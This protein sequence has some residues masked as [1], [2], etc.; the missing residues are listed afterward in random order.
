MSSLISSFI[1]EPVVRQARRFS[2]APTQAHIPVQSHVKK[3]KLRSG[4]EVTIIEGIGAA[5]CEIISQDAC[6]AVIGPGIGEGV[7]ESRILDAGFV[8]TTRTSPTTLVPG[9]ISVPISIQHADVISDNAVEDSITSEL[10]EN[11]TGQDFGA[12]TSTTDDT[13]ILD[14]E[15]EEFPSNPA[16]DPPDIMDNEHSSTP[17]SPRLSRNSTLRRTRPTLASRENTASSL[18][19]DDGMRLMRQRIHA[20]R[21]LAETPED[22]ARRM[23]DLMTAE[24]QAAQFQ[25]R[26]ESP[27]SITS[28]DRE[29][30]RPFL[31]SSPLSTS[32]TPNSPRSI[33]SLPNNPANPY[34]ITPEDLQ[35]SYR[36][37]PADSSSDEDITPPVLSLGCSHYKRNVK[38]QCY[39]CKSWHTCRHC[40]DSAQHSHHLNRKATEN[41]LCMLCG[42][43][44]PAGQWC[45]GC[46][47][48]TAWYYCDIC[49]LW[50]DDSTKGIYHC[51]DCGICRRGEGL[52]KDFVH[53]KKCNVCISISHYPMHTCIENATDSNCPLCL[54]YMFTSPHEIV[55]MPCGHYLHHAC[56]SQ[57]ML[58][59]YQ[60]P[61]CKRSAVNMETQWRKLDEEIRRQ[62]MP[63]EFEDARMEVRCNDCGGRS[64]VG[65]HWL[66]CRCAV[67]DGFNTVEV[68]MIGDTAVQRGVEDFATQARERREAEQRN[69]ANN[70]RN[71]D[72]PR[73][74]NA[75]LNVRPY[76]EAMDD[77]AALERPSSARSG[78]SGFGMPSLPNMPN[79]PN[80]PNLNPY[81]MLARVSRG[82][83]PIRHYFDGEIIDAVPIRFRGGNAGEAER[84]WVDDGEWWV[85]SE[86]DDSSD[87]SEGSDDSEDGSGS[88]EDDDDTDEEEIVHEGDDDDGD[89]GE[90]EL[91][92]FG[93]R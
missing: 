19:A 36:P 76:F 8:P 56:Y 70:P 58:S 65:F 10:Q 40:H 88:E 78:D 28:Q 73:R 69:W 80:L 26:P 79:M 20:I 83:S 41:M 60:C 4:D 25:F 52:G 23:H 37:I 85:D 71:F 87:G 2:N 38:I 86:E 57:L 14:E 81:E 44:Q 54:D 66:G 53:C 64:A 46:G 42:T 74:V 9:L 61:I 67:C 92:L 91:S 3:S 77:S 21:E 27:A 16:S 18:P 39:D 84:D 50:D 31:A 7:P 45:K 1:I 89:G 82:L 59:S 63:R 34:N 75:P 32:I 13:A 24:W 5:H 33:T 62:P 90:L 47:E 6:E 68:R 93:H 29:R 35:P 12:V 22:K 49:K 15:L 51:G 11:I 17:S 72:I 55:A 48:K 43:A 30:E